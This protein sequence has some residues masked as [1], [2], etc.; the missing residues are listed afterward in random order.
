[1]LLI[2]EFNICCRYA[3]VAINYLIKR[4]MV[5]QTIIELNDFVIAQL[6][7]Y[8]TESAFRNSSISLDL[9]FLSKCQRRLFIFL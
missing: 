9:I 7:Q 2:L 6:F 5:K 8:Q 1:M 4:K 3:D